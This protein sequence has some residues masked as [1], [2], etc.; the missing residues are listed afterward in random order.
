MEPDVR[1]IGALFDQ[2]QIERAEAA[3]AEL[4]T[5]RADLAAARAEKDSA[6]ELRRLCNQRVMQGL[7]RIAL[8]IEDDEPQDIGAVDILASLV[9]HVV[10]ERQEAEDA[11]MAMTSARDEALAE[12]RLYKPDPGFD[13]GGTQ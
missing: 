8:A 4:A 7:R 9:E 5:L 12:V 10:R 1:R 3:E 13:Q 6:H 11:L 2:K